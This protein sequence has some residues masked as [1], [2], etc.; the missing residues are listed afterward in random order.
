MSRLLPAVLM[1]RRNLTRTKV[2]SILAALGIVIGV[3][4]IASLGMLGTTLRQQATQ[5]LGDIGNQVIVSPAQEADENHITDR[6]LQ[7]IERT[8]R[9][10]EVVPMVEGIEDL[11]FGREETTT[12]VYYFSSV[13]SSYTATDGDIPDPLRG[14]ALVGADLAD[15]IDL[16]PGNSITVN[17]TSYRVRAT[18]EGSGSFFSPINP[19]NAVVLPRG[20]RDEI[21][22]VVITADTGPEA[23]ATAVALRESL[24]DRRS[25]QVNVRELSDITEDINEFFGFINAFLIGL[26]S[27]SLLVAGVSILNVMLMSTVERREEIGVLRAVGFQKRDVLKIMLTEAALL[28]LAGGV[29]GA[30]LAVGVGMLVAQFALGDPTAVLIPENIQFVVLGVGFGLVTSVLSGLYPAWKAANEHPVEALRG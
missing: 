30:V 11:E 12:Q 22:Q 7:D 17:G 29:I 5:N 8:A 20:N 14:G 23:N 25:E 13:P 21:S 28:G 24:N 4:A 6:Q 2:R 10:K 19:N 18:V 27:I 16:E 9:G 1:A 15:R 26:G 3:I